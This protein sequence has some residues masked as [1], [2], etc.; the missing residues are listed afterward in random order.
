[1]KPSVSRSELKNQTSNNKTYKKKIWCP[2]ETVPV[3]RNA[4]EF[5]TNTQFVI[6]QYFHPL[7][8]DSPG[9]HVSVY[10]SSPYI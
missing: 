2:Y 8:V 1:M 5:M 10:L 7:S 9:T 4:N 3:L 6:D